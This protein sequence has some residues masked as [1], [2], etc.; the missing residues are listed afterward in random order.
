MYAHNGAAVACVL[1]EQVDAGHTR[2]EKATLPRVSGRAARYDQGSVT[3]HNSTSAARRTP[4]SSSFPT[5]V[6]SELLA[7]PALV[8]A[9]RSAD[10]RVHFRGLPP[11]QLL[12]DGKMVRP[13][14]FCVQ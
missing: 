9:A 14:G 1:T 12:S 6:V 10:F 11:D 2:E 4:L 5:R 8:T 13:A 3:C 7:I